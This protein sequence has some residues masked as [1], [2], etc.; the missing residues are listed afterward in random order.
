MAASLN[1]C[2]AET[3]HAH[4]VSPIVAWLNLLCVVI[5]VGQLIWEIW[6]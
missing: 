3:F 2:I 1:L 5:A 4:S 6:H